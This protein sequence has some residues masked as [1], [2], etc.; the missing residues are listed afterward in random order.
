MKAGIPVIG[1]VFIVFLGVLLIVFV[2][3]WAMQQFE[4]QQYKG[5]MLAVERDFNDCAKK[6]LSVTRTGSSERCVFS[7]TR[8]T[9]EI[10]K[11]GLYYRLHSP[12]PI[13]EPHEW[14]MKS[15]ATKVWTRCS[16]DGKVFEIRWL[17]PK[18]DTVV[19]SGTVT[20]LMPDGTTRTFDLT[21]KGALNVEFTREGVIRG[22]II[23]ITRSKVEKDKTILSL[24]VVE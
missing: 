4:A 13:C 10:K 24:R 7:A 14:R 11:D 23:E 3:P 21:N 2:F 22:K 18:N 19:I 15:L 6:L 16:N 17:Y 5:E 12:L 20:L 9:F 1:Y 8:G